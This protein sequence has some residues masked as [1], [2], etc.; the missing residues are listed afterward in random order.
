VE[1]DHEGIASYLAGRRVLVTGAGGSIG[2][3]LC[4]QIARFEPDALV[5]L[6]QAENPLFYI[7]QELRKSYPDLKLRPVIADICDSKRLRDVFER[8]QPEVVFHAAAHKHVPMMEMNPGE[9][10]KNNVFGTKK[11]ADAADAV[12]CGVMVMISTDKAVNP[13]S[14]MGATKR[15]AELY[16][17]SIAKR[18]KTKFVAVRFGNVLGS[19]GSVIPTFKKQIEEGGPVT[20]THPDMKRYFMTIP[21]ACQ[22]VMQAASLAEGGEIFVLDMGK[23]VKIVDLARD[24]IQALGAAGRA[25]RAGGVHG[26]AAGGE[27][28]RGAGLQ[29]GAGDQDAAREGVHR[30]AGGLPRGEGAGDPDAAGGSDG[31][32]RG[33][34]RAGGAEGALAGVLGADGGDFQRVSDPGGCAGGDSGSRG[35]S[36]LIPPTLCLCLSGFLFVS[37]LR[38]RKTKRKPERQRQRAAADGGPFSG[39]EHG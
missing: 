10:V 15:L 19:S 5:M 4:R 17:Q 37:L 23:P 21:E 24:M 30:E 9:A 29:R 28:V 8:F 27:A 38:I 6:E 16:I 26:A 22:L 31:D 14:V 32:E 7:E 18:S 1:L 33:G 20:V 34:E 35:S 2:S 12:G 39:L 25:G 13:T 11:V 3:E 36:G